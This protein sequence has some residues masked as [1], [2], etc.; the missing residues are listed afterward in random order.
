M[1]AEA[2]VAETKPARANPYSPVKARLDEVVEETPTI[3][4]FVLSPEER[5][6]W[7]TGQFVEVAVPGLG[8]APYTPSNNQ[9]DTDR[10]EVTVMKA[11]LVTGRMHELEAGAELGI[12][13]PLGKGYP[14]E[15]FEGR[16]I[17][18]LGGG[19]GLAPLRSL[20]YALLNEKEEYGRLLVCY[21]AKTPDDL[22][23]R[24]SYE[25]WGATDGVDL[26]LTVDK[27]APGWSGNVGVV[28]TLLDK[29][30]LDPQ[31]M[32]AVVCGPP[33]M[34]KFGTVK[35]IEL[36]FPPESIYLSME[37]NMSCGVGMCGHCRLGPYFVCKDGPVFT[38]DQ[39]KDLRNI[40]D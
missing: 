24:A 19:V 14:L 2:A 38:Y 34:M 6:P 40:W 11:G 9:K 17:L 27:E 22:L 29:V 32:P 30:E 28:T 37:K 35:L 23:Y 20:F 15:K 12:R 26:N 33:I 31:K 25:E 36:G 21:G 4:T 13:G 18:I 5:I 7:V 3:K 16:D 10:I 1:T 39:V 8:E